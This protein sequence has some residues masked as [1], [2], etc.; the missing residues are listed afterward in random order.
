MTKHP[1]RVLLVLIGVISTMPVNAEV[2]PISNEFFSSPAKSKAV[3]LSRK[4]AADHAPIKQKKVTPIGIGRNVASKE[5]DYNIKPADQG[6]MQSIPEVANAI[7]LSAGM[8]TRSTERLADSKCVPKKFSDD[9]YPDAPQNNPEAVV[10]YRKAIDQ[11]D[12]E[13]QFSLGMIYANG[14]QGIL[15]DNKISVEWYRKAAEQGL[16]KAQYQLGRM[17]L[18]GQGVPYDYLLAVKCFSMAAEYDPTG[19][20]FLDRENLKRT[21][22]FH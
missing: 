6:T 18:Y 14:L 10:L 21:V 13:A 9:S 16:A 20:Q 19:S 4:I 7:T 1:M 2:L 17:Y 8:K 11:K 22:N 5:A 3:L 12:V 15:K